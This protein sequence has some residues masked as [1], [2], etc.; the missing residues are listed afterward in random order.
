MTTIE[1]VG[2]DDLEYIAK[3]LKAPNF[4]ECVPAQTGKKQARG[5]VIERNDGSRF[6]VLLWRTSKGTHIKRE[7]M[8]SEV[9]RDQ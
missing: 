7:L 6:G 9:I 4:D 5:I 1:G 3:L 2:A 8:L